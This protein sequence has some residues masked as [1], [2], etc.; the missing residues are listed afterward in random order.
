MKKILVLACMFI[1]T[2]CSA[3]PF[4]VLLLD[5]KD[6]TGQKPDQVLGGGIAPGAL[7]QKGIY[8]FGKQLLNSGSY[9]LIDRRDF[10][11]EMEKVAVKNKIEGKDAT[12][13]FL[14]AAQILG[15]DTVL[16]SS[17]LSFSSGKQKV[18]QGGYKTELTTLSIR[19]VLEALDSVDGAV[20]GMAEGVADAQ[21]RQTQSVE[22]SLSENDVLQLLDQ[23][24]SKA[25]PEITRAM[26]ARKSRKDT[27]KVLKISIVSNADPAMVEIDGV[28]VG[29]TPLKNHEIYEGDHVITVGKPGYQDINKR[30]AFKKDTEITVPMLRTQLTMEELKEVLEKMR[31]HS[32]AVIEPPVM[33]RTME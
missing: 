6:E 21:F 27:R 26:E 28:L 25:I 31:F 3:D 12:P 24:F 4:R 23:A 8:S 33:I 22:T 11:S 13:S 1:A 32:I 2:V 9:V 20:I 18:D 16:R 29:T 5:C 15:A 19:V 14:H 7:A 17:L 30:I 10:A